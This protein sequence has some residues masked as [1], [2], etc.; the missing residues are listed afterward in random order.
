MNAKDLAIVLDMA[1]GRDSHHEI[2]GTFERTRY[3]ALAL[4][5]SPQNYRYKGTAKPKPI[6]HRRTYLLKRE[7]AALARR[8]DAVQVMS[9]YEQVMSAMARDILRPKALEGMR[10][11]S[12]A[13]CV[14]LSQ[15]IV[16]RI[17][18][19]VLEPAENGTQRRRVLTHESCE[20]VQQL[21]EK[22]AKCASRE[23]LSEALKAMLMEM[24]GNR[25]LILTL[26]EELAPHIARLPHVAT[27]DRAIASFA[28]FVDLGTQE[29]FFSRAFKDL[30]VLVMEKIIRRLPL[31]QVRGHFDAMI[32]E[33]QLQVLDYLVT[34]PPDPM[35]A[36]TSVYELKPW[37]MSI[38]PEPDVL[39]IRPE[40]GVYI[41][42]SKAQRAYVSASKSS[43][44]E[45]TLSQ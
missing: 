10:D 21:I 37:S 1:S 5:R 43:V 16:E 17:P 24:P 31:A 27:V 9:V 29:R 45:P 15:G 26:I 8:L 32:S 22:K 42:G 11:L 18:F 25:A 12:L 39:E 34:L 40:S 41:T 28:W 19:E 33:C 44:S 20:N 7:L 30:Y 38:T 23:E 3:V 35:S 36:T 4:D 14:H 13:Q 6:L 2:S